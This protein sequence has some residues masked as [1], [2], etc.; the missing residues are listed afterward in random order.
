[1][2]PETPRPYFVP[3]VVALHIRE[4]TAKSYI[5]LRPSPRRGRTYLRPWLSIALQ[6][7]VFIALV[8]TIYYAATP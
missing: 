1:M 3:G 6:T 5:D 4:A 2:K 8:A 7:A